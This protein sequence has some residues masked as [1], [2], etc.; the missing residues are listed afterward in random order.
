MENG[1]SELASAIQDTSNPMAEKG[2]KK[3]GMRWLWL[4]ILIPAVYGTYRAVTFFLTPGRAIQQVYLI[5]K[6]AIYII[7]SSSPVADWE[8]FSESA[9]WYC[10]KRSLSFAEIDRNASVLDSILHENRKL[11][12]LVGKRD[13]MISA[14]KVRSG[15]LDYL[16]VIDLQKISEMETL[17]DQIE[18]I[19]SL[20]N[21]KVTYRKYQHKDIIELRDPKTREILYTAFVENHFIASYS[22]K[23]IEASINEQSDPVIG[24]DPRFME[25]DRLV[26]DKGLFRIYVHYAY[27]PQF[28]EKY[29]SK[30]N[31]YLSAISRSMAFAGL[32]FNATKDK[33]D[34]DGYTLLNDTVDPYISTLLHSGK[35]EMK[36]HQILSAR[37][38]F[39]TNISFDEPATF[40]KELEKALSSNS[41]DFY[42]TYQKSYRKIESTFGI[43]L[44]DDFLSWMSGE[45]ALIELEPGLLGYDTE[46]ILCIQAKNINQAKERMASIERSVKRHTPV[47]V[48]KVTYKDYDINYVELKGFFSLFFGKMF[49][50]FEKPYYTYI[51]D[52]VVFSNKPSTILSFIEDRE[53]GY[54]L[55]DDPDFKQVLGQVEK[56]STYFLYTNTRKFFP[57]LKPVLNAKSWT[58]LNNNKEIAFSFPTMGLQI[59]GDRHR[60]PIHL[61]LNFSPYQEEPVIEDVDLEDENVVTTERE[62]LEELQRF[63]VEKFQGN[64]YREYYQDGAIRIKCEIK[65]GRR[66]GTYHEYYENGILKIRGKY[67]KGQSKGTWKYYT[68]EGKFDKK[69][70]I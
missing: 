4:L 26:A 50:K 35:K 34:L 49:D 32:S 24:L 61:V 66:H 52:Y 54:I 38:A 14:H 60:I 40:L 28:L 43:S 10:L 27:L 44:K 51:D 2:K 39:Y 29:D 5:P 16:F 48:K 45:F 30:E 65:D 47:N 6:D 31:E 56:H 3:Q 63:Y 59:I 22:S 23:L 69:V 57:L 11:F 25:V 36:A 55:N 1:K 58:D 46:M 13:L 18:H 9:P 12:S 17:K 7:H 21:Y 62:I 67:A 64:I 41:P 33:F 68:E 53:Q 42:D 8:K 37:T 20:M 15:V 70:K 19:Y